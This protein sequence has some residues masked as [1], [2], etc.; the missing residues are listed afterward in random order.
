MNRG[1]GNSLA[2]IIV[3]LA[4]FSSGVFS[5]ALWVFGFHLAAVI[6]IGLVGLFTVGLLSKRAP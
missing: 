1:I 2:I 5:Y 3:L 4:L 6:P